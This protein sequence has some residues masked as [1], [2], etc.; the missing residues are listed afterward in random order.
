MS[1]QPVT[2]PDDG[3]CHPDDV[4]VYFDKYSEDGF[5]EDTNP[6]KD[7]VQGIIMAES[8]WI[9][10]FT[11]HAWRARTVRN[12][13]ISM[14][15]TF[16]WRA[17]TPI[18]LMHRDIRTPLDPDQGDKLEIWAGSRWRDWLTDGNYE[19][20]REKD[21]WLDAEAGIL[22]IWRRRVWWQRHRE[23]RVTYRYGKEDVPPAIRDACARRVASYFL[24]AQQ[25]RITVPG[26]EEAPDP[27]AIA[28]RWREQV[29]RD[30]QPYKEVRSIG[31]V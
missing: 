25:Y 17:G 12:E 14:P 13:L 4:A 26:N 7:Q 8:D 15:H 9:D 3:Y 23:L 22:Y 2:D 11:G 6:T 29:E 27:S 16:Y 1:V 19:E 21:F 18:K 10:Q 31:Q 20:G 28:E 5:T 30:L 24:E